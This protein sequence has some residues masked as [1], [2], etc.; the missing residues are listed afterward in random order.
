MSRPATIP[1]AAIPS[2]RC[3]LH[4]GLLLQPVS[5]SGNPPLLRPLRGSFTV[6]NIFTDFKRHD[7]GP[8]FHEREYDGTLRTEFLT[9]ALWGVGSTAPYGHDGRTLSL[10]DVIRRHGGEAQDARDNF[11]SLSS[12]SRS[13]I[14]AFLNSLLLFSPDDTPSNLEGGGIDPA[15]PR[16]PQVGHGSIRL[17]ALFL[18][19][20][21]PE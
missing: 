18:N 7:L 10:E 1:I 11:A 19:P 21:D 17:T 12:S 3:S 16:Y 13:A 8:N 14:L 5:G 15:N 6:R 20:N 9:T 4:A 2:I